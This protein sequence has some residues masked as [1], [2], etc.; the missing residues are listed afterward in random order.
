M[1][2][3]TG[4]RRTI[5]KYEYEL[6]TGE[7]KGVR[8]GRGTGPSWAEK[9]EGAFRRHLGGWEKETWLWLLVRH[10]MSQKNSRSSPGGIIHSHGTDS[11]NSR[12]SRKTMIKSHS[13]VYRQDST[14]CL[15]LRFFIFL[16]FL[17][18]YF[19]SCLPFLFLDP[20]ITGI[21][22]NLGL[23]ALQLHTLTTRGHSKSG[24][25]KTW[26]LFF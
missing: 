12:L 5:G 23:F 19:R 17:R 10:V 2:W 14:L 11:P 6:K 26:P 1:R 18:T 15:A 13:Q 16:F 20:G 22:F 24:E 8:E 9:K 3:L 25:G 4:T 7:V 21:K